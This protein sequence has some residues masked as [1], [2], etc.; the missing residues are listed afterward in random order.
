MH[1]SNNNI[2][3]H[4]AVLAFIDCD[5]IS[6]KDE[7]A[8]EELLR[9]VGRYR[10]RVEIDKTTVSLGRPLTVRVTVEGQG[11]ISRVEV[12]GLPE[13]PGYRL[14]PPVYDK[15]LQVTGN[16]WV[17][18]SKTAEIVLTPLQP[19]KLEIPRLEFTFFDP[20]KKSYKTLHSR[21]HA[22]TVLQARQAP[23]LAEEELIER[24]GEEEPHAVKMARQPLSPLRQIGDVESSRPAASV[25]NLF[26]AG[27]LGT[28]AA[29]FGWLLLGFLRRK[30]RVSAPA[31]R[32]RAAPARARS[33]LA[34][35]SRLESEGHSGRAVVEVSGAL[36]EF[37]AA[38]LGL[39]AG[40]VSGPR[41]ERM[42]TA[43]GVEIATI[44]RLND[45]RSRCD[46]A[47][48][49]PTDDIPA[50]ALIVEAEELICALGRLGA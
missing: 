36:N 24:V 25:G 10:F 39:S 32:R 34:T 46:L 44:R 7:L 16:R 5:V 35:A 11:M 43:N 17:G 4:Q 19:G 28:P 42:L 21:P 47:R 29:Y 14:L 45:L 18:G 33:R 48:F 3:N 2:A 6:G 26:W 37:V 12:P 31:R 50:A 40:A 22:V 15:K 1:A 41:L 38:S 8:R 13:S 30:W 49:S 20:A 9:N 23:A 27:L